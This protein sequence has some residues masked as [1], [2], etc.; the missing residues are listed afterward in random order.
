MT[1][2]EL[3]ELHDLIENNIEILNG[4]VSTKFNINLLTNIENIKAEVNRIKD[5]TNNNEF[6]EYELKRD[7]LCI[8]YA[9]KSKHTDDPLIVNNQYVLN[10]ITQDE[11]KAK[12]TELKNKYKDVIKLQTQ[13]IKEYNDELNKQSNIVLIR[14]K[15]YL[16]ENLTFEQLKIIFKM[17]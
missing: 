6:I 17:L 5:I 1:N 11:F 4:I 7:K 14:L 3:F 15:Q 9:E 13:K 12:I 2:L 10:P 8:Q 16:P